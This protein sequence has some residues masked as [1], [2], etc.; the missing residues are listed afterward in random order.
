MS[1]RYTRVDRLGAGAYGVVYKGKCKL[2][3]AVV[4]VKC[5]RLDIGDEGV[6]CTTVREVSLLKE[7]R[8]PNIVRLID[9]CPHAGGLALVFEYMELDLRRYINASGGSL[10]GTTLQSLFR[11]LMLGVQ[12]CHARC[13]L[14]RDLKPQNLLVNP[15]RIELKVADFG[16]ARA[17]GV[18]VRRYTHEVVTLWYRSPDVLLGS[19]SYGHGVDLWSCGCI[20]G[21]M[22]EGNAL[23]RGRSEADQLLKTFKFLGTPGRDVFPSMLNYPSSAALLSQPCF[24]QLYSPTCD[25]RLRQHNYA[26]KLGDAGVDLLKGLLEWEPVR[27]LDSGAAL[28]HP[29]FQKAPKE[30]E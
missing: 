1:L 7:L 21:E 8:H 23:I 29:F 10:S 24:L 20:L 27:R 19:V 9:V 14:H 18:P 13:I 17:Y 28:V 12:C 2:S 25:T 6:P 30:V 22:A 16:L 5:I 3:G 26:S 4:A 15:T 11:Q